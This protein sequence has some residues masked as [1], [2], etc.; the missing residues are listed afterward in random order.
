VIFALHNPVIGLLPEYLP[1]AIFALPAAAFLIAVRRKEIDGLEAAVYWF[2]LGLVLFSAAMPWVAVTYGASELGAY[3]SASPYHAAGALLLAIA[4]TSA[5]AIL[6][7]RNR[8]LS[9]PEIG[10]YLLGLV[11]WLYVGW[12]FT[13]T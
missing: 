6:A 1:I 9:K 12:R 13:Q 7:W 10:V 5:L 11:Y 4:V 2:G 3:L 8:R